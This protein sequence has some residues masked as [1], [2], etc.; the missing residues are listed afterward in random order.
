MGKVG[1]SALGANR[2]RAIPSG[3]SSLILTRVITGTVMLMF[4]A[5]G[6]V[7]IPDSIR[8]LL[9]QGQRASQILVTA[10]LLNVALMWLCWKRCRTLEQEVEHLEHAKEH[11]RSL[12][13]RDPLT[14]FLN[15]RSLAEAASGFLKGPVPRAAALLVIDLDHFKK[16]NDLHGHAVGDDLLRAV[17]RILEDCTPAGSACARLGGDEF[18]VLLVGESAAHRRATEIA[19]TIVGRLAAPIGV[20]GVSAHVG[21][22]LGLS[23]ADAECS[24]IETLLRR[25][26]IA[27][28]ESK[29][30]GRNRFAW[31]DDSMEV[32]LRRRNIIEEGIRRGIP[33]GEFVPYFERQVDLATGELRGFEML[34]RWH[35]PVNGLLEPAEFI[36][37]AEATGLI[38]DLSLAVMRQALLVA[39]DWDSA[40][41]IAVNIS[42]VQVKDPLLPQLIK[43]VLVD[44]GF[45]AQRLEI[46]ITESSLFEDL[47]LAQATVESLK[48]QGIRISLDD[49]GTGYSSLGHL[50]SLPFDRIKIDR[51]FI[52][53]MGASSESSAIVH[54]ISKLG[55]TLG[56]PV[57]AE[58]IEDE[59]ARKR[60]EALGCSDGQG[61]L[62]GRPLPAAEVSEI[63]RGLPD[64]SAG[65]AAPGLRP[66]AR[67]ARSGT[68]SGAGRR[69][70]G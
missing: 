20:S 41:T 50:N 40:L 56:L 29:K 18:A 3:R 22:S 23:A 27:M 34:A 28:Y 38:S 61:W 7:V 53:S 31:F 55:A 36:G 63:L 13:N 5:V 4:V 67:R 57:T 14:G 68:R 54:A 47:E 1:V 51:S 17:A 45:P 59:D 24:D 8:I 6:S 19:A 12:A 11:A 16:I 21:A 9:D 43:Q 70:S 37:V 52:A 58:G 15:R 33:A 48:N 26:D 39:R 35:H 62:F 65:Q 64:A 10:L 69:H 44:T 49:F 30:A 42:P 66:A 2:Q 32:E 46:E 25:S 60:L